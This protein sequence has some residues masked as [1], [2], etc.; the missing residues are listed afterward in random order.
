MG[1]VFLLR[2]IINS[3]AKSYTGYDISEKA[4]SRATNISKEKK[5]NE[6]AFFFQNLL[7]K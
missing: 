4:I 2:K 6:K 7:K 5:I 1:Q 3:G